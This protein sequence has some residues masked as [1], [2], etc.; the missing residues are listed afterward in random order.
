MTLDQVPVLVLVRHHPNLVPLVRFWVWFV[1]RSR[2]VV[3]GRYRV[4]EKKRM[5]GDDLV[6]PLA[7]IVAVLI[8]ATLVVVM[9]G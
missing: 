5:P 8:L 6:L 2:M 9:L 3:R 1:M 7:E 4:S